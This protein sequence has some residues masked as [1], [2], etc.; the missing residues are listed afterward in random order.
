[1]SWNFMKRHPS[2]LFL[3]LS[4]RSKITAAPV[5]I[6]LHSMVV[7]CCSGTACG[8]ESKF[9]KQAACSRLE[10]LTLGYTDSREREERERERGE[11]SV[12]GRKGKARRGL[13]AHPALRGNPL[14]NLINEVAS[15]RSST[16]RRL[17]MA[18]IYCFELIQ[19]WKL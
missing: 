10:N 15:L 9:L 6:I 7:R 17:T 3:S 11:R 8:D 19:C 18:A 12:L 14:F 16:W 1:M 4:S 13:I 5:L 2:S